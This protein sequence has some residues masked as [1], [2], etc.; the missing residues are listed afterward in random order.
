MSIHKFIHLFVVYVEEIDIEMQFNEHKCWEKIRDFI[1]YVTIN[2]Y[3][4]SISYRLYRLPHRFETT[5]KK[6]TIYLLTSS[7]SSSSRTQCLW[8]FSHRLCVPLSVL[9]LLLLF[10]RVVYIISFFFIHFVNMWSYVHVHVYA[11]WWYSIGWV[12]IMQTEA[13]NLAKN[14]LNWNLSSFFFL[15]ILIRIKGAYNINPKNK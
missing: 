4:P 2:S 14:T 10:R 15:L 9:L 11:C 7:S 5:E 6:K 8:L 12:A 1:L 13:E 3:H